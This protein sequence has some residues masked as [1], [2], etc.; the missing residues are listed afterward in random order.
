GNAGGKGVVLAAAGRLL[1]CAKERT[2]WIWKLGLGVSY[3]YACMVIEA[4]NAQTHRRI[5]QK[6]AP[7][8]AG[9]RAQSRIV[10]KLERSL[11]IDGYE[12]LAAVR[13][14]EDARKRFVRA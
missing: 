9:A 5:R 7:G 8:I 1:E 6:L 14:V 4:S 12:V 10:D 3:R 2:W 11:G 13:G